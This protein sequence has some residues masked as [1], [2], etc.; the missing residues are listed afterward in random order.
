MFGAVSGDGREPVLPLTL[1]GH[2]GAS[3]RRLRLEAIVDTGF[4]GELTLPPEMIRRLGYPHL[5][6]TAATLADGSEV[7]VDYFA[8]SVSWH[9]DPR[10]VVLL[11]ADGKP[12]IGMELLASSRLTVEVMPGGDVT[13]EGL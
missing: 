4:D 2:A 11:A 9:G 8:G 6:T 10:A 12:L 3:D 7:Q 5:G 1:L 13:V